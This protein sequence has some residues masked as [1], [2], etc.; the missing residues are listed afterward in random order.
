MLRA[1]GILFIVCSV[2]FAGLI[3]IGLGWWAIASGTVQ[4]AGINQAS[5]HTDVAPPA[6]AVPGSQIITRETHPQPLPT[7]GHAVPIHT[8][9]LVSTTTATAVPAASFVTPSA[10]EV[11]VIFQDNGERDESLFETMKQLELHRIVTVGSNGQIIAWSPSTTLPAILPNESTVVHLYF[12]GKSTNPEDYTTLENA[13]DRANN[14]DKAR[15]G[16]I[17]LEVDF[18]R[19][20]AVGTSGDDFALKLVYG[21]LPH[22][23]ALNLGFTSDVS[24]A[25]AGLVRVE[26]RPGILPRPEVHAAYN[27]PHQPDS[28]PLKL[29][30]DTSPTISLP[31]Q[32]FRMSYVSQVSPGNTRF[33]MMKHTGAA[34]DVSRQLETIQ[35]INATPVEAAPNT[36]TVAF[37]GVTQFPKLSTGVRTSISLWLMATDGKATVLSDP[38]KLTL[39]PSTPSIVGDVAI[40]SPAKKK[41]VSGS[42]TAQLSVTNNPTYADL[43]ITTPHRVIS[44]R[45]TNGLGDP[46]HSESASPLDLRDLSALHVPLTLRHDGEQVITAH[47]YRGTKKLRSATGSKDAQAST[48]V[49]ALINGPRITNI[50][51][52]QFTDTPDVNKIVLQFDRTYTLARVPAEEKSNYYIQQPDGGSPTYATAAVLDNTNNRVTVTFADNIFPG[53]WRFIV[54]SSNPTAVVSA[55]GEAEQTDDRTITDIAGNRL[56]ATAD[57]DSGSD[58]VKLLNRS[59]IGESALSQR[60]IGSAGTGEHVEFPEYTKPRDYPSGFNPSDKVVTRVAR[61]Y[62]FRDAHRV[63]QIVNR[64][65]Q[66][67]NRQAVD[68][69]QQFADAARRDADQATVTRREAERKA[70]RAAQSARAAEEALQEHQQALIRARDRVGRLT[71]QIAVM[72]GMIAELEQTV[73]AAAGQT[74]LVESSISA[75]TNRNGQ[76][77]EKKPR[78]LTSEQQLRRMKSNRQALIDQRNQ[79]QLDEKQEV[80]A[81]NMLLATVQAERTSEIRET[82]RWEALEEEERLKAEE[83]FRRE[84]AAKTEDPDTYVAGDPESDDPVTQVSLSVVGEGL[85]QM[86]GPRKGVNEVH[87]MINQ[88]DAPVG[89]VKVALHTVQVNGEGGDRMEQVVMRIQRYLDHSRFLTIQSGQMLRNAV[90]SVASE[91]ATMVAGTCPPGTPQ[92]LRDYKYQEAFFGADF[93]QELRN[94]DSEFLRTGN[95]VLS[96]HSM[97]TTSLSN[98][99]FLLSL[100]KNDVR[101]EILARFMADVQCKLPQDEQEFF[102]ESGAEYKFRHKEFQFLGQNAQFVA[103]RG[104]FDAQVA[105]P[106]T[107]NP[108]QREFIR[109]A[110]IFKARLITEIELRQRVMERALIEERIGTAEEYRQ[111]ME[112]AKAAEQKAND[113]IRD[114]RGRIRSRLPTILKTVE[115]L[116]TTAGRVQDQSDE[117]IQ[118]HRTALQIAP[119][120]S[121]LEAITRAGVDKSLLPIA[122]EMQD[123]LF[124]APATSIPG[125]ATAPAA[126]PL[127]ARF[128]EYKRRMNEL[129][130]WGKDKDCV[131]EQVWDEYRK[132]VEAAPS[133]RDKSQLTRS[134]R[135]LEE[136][137]TDLKQRYRLS[138]PLQEYA[139]VAERLIAKQNDD[140]AIEQLDRLNRLALYVHDIQLIVAGKSQE[141]FKKLES[142]A[143]SLEKAA[144]ARDGVDQVHEITKT[145][146]KLY[147]NIADYVKSG[148][149][150]YE[151][152]QSGNTAFAELNADAIRLTAAVSNAADLRRPLDHKKFLDMLVDDVEE[153]FIELVE[154]TRAQTSNIDNYLKRLGTALEDDFNAQFYHPAFRYVRETSYFYD[155]SVGQVETTSIVANNRMFAKVE[156]QATMEFDLPKRDILI[157]EAMNSALAAYNDYGA[158]MA[159]PNFLSLMSMYG[160]QPASQT[161]GQQFGSPYVQEVLPGLPATTDA[162]FLTSAK[163]NVPRLGSSL[164]ALIPDPAIYKFQTGTGF[165]IRPVIQPDGQS[166]VF[167][168]NYMYSTNVREPVR[169]DEKHLGRVKRH[170]IDTDVVTGN[171]EL[172]EVSTYRVGLKA[173]RTS[174]GV[175]LL[176]DIPAVGVL[177]RPQASAESS[178]Q[179]NIILTQSVIYPTLFDLMGLRWAPAVADLDSLTLQ[180]R[181]FVT[182]NREKFLQNE[183]FDYS[184]LQVDEFMRIPDGERRGDLYRTQETIPRQHPNGYDGPG[185]NIRHGHLQEGYQPEQFYPQSK[186]IPRRSEDAP[187]FQEEPPRQPVYHAPGQLLL[188]QPVPPDPACLEGAMSVTPSDHQSRAAMLM[189]EPAEEPM[190]PMS[191]WSD[192][193]TNSDVVPAQLVT[194]PASTEDTSWMTPIEF[195]SS[196]PEDRNPSPN[197]STRPSTQ[198]SGNPQSAAAIPQAAEQRRVIRRRP[199]KKRTAVSRLVNGLFNR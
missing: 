166:V 18:L 195:G 162:Q 45:I 27:G 146:T 126:K 194:E 15:L 118:Q 31:S 110:Q 8:A 47:V 116:R 4:I 48:T 11:P 90:V 57:D 75:D 117:S 42:L 106:D 148:T 19:D 108:M 156:P 21:A 135:L 61:L 68:M 102:V 114:L 34:D 121:A 191:H 12:R 89:Q 62:Y 98:A 174:R 122:Q 163:N 91:R 123:E 103:L 17:C 184:S 29:D 164:E 39:E 133:M 63:T 55:D 178:L 197:H 105:G 87:K 99:L 100:A 76:S 37:D 128:K 154:G 28:Q 54:R 93:M 51:A 192:L 43:V 157:N 144:K 94:M 159:D 14:D 189:P 145:W 120:L 186:F 58:F 79:A 119:A 78:E 111:H 30:F 60:G 151:H 5:P 113:E 139:K 125:E 180:E 6:A 129:T 112:A 179:Q 176:E 69:K 33:L 49:N 40:A 149:R 24:T 115:Q 136:Q 172:R 137:L 142:L 109:L 198:S 53:Q 190:T 134:F 83:Q 140:G 77:S 97:D 182:R 127:E 165:E 72:D 20:A 3:A 9:S 170:F 25:S 74:A 65:A 124:I 23:R 132:S 153:K 138:K 67:Y 50:N 44:H 177:F 2:M 185:L 64:Q 36:Y 188:P 199:K 35:V 52:S 95:K 82:E 86:R 32:Y 71:Q 152:L 196:A 59:A 46:Y 38:L 141:A 181:E 16:R 175:P 130:G 96:L 107:L 13:I 167:H 160:G 147:S 88:I 80:N 168:L 150:L 169:A 171:Y 81:V 187:E 161:Y 84:V 22:D 10:D 56:N 92:Q 7:I 26:D 104:F 85:I 41:N 66:S 183:V 158:L 101:E 1:L 143:R 70:I 73:A 173:S 155:V 131:W 193:D